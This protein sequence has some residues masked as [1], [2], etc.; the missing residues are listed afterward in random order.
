MLIIES[1]KLCRNV[2]RVSGE[3]VP[4]IEPSQQFDPVSGVNGKT[5]MKCL[6]FIITSHQSVWCQYLQQYDPVCGVD[7]KTYGNAC[8]AACAGVAVVGKGECGKDPLARS[9]TLPGKKPCYCT[10]VSQS[11]MT[12]VFSLCIYLLVVYF[13]S[14]C[15]Q[16]LPLSLR[17]EL[18]CVCIS[19]S[20]Y[21]TVRF[22]N[23]VC[24]SHKCVG[25]SVYTSTG[26]CHTHMHALWT[27]CGKD[28][29]DW[30]VLFPA[31]KPC[32]CIQVGQKAIEISG[33]VDS[34]I[35]ASIDWLIDWL[36]D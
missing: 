27:K 10:Q 26:S 23:V 31:K 4:G 33:S 32:C 7:G 12:T 2:I 14:I 18:N 3:K 22:L 30:S 16:R 11:C 1:L 25:Q 29:V 5:C 15:G 36:I 6:G 13:T 9:V 19:Q 28:L 24:V 35:H 8:T 17:L 20:V 34:Q 21:L